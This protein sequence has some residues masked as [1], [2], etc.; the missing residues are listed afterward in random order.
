MELE[1]FDKKTPDII[2]L[3]YLARHM[4][5]PFLNDLDEAAWRK[6]TDA[7]IAKLTDDVIAQAVRNLPP[8]IHALSGEALTQ[9][10]LDRRRLMPKAA[11]EYYR[12]LA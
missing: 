11:N 6:V 3:T 12:N 1:G 8:E 4:D 7:F 2:S 5:R 9:K 10:L